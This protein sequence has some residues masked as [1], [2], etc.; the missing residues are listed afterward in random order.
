MRWGK[1]EPKPSKL[2]ILELHVWWPYLSILSAYRTHLPLG[3][4]AL[5]VCSSCVSWP[6]HLKH[7]GV[8]SVTKASLLQLH[9]M[10]S[11]DPHAFCLVSMFRGN[12]GG[13]LHNPLSSVSFMTV[14]SATWTRRALPTLASLGWTLPPRGH[15]CRACACY[16]V[17]GTENSLGLFFPQVLSLA[18]CRLALR[19]HSLISIHIRPLFNI[20]K[21]KPWLQFYNFWCSYSLQN[22]HLMFLFVLFS[23]FHCRPA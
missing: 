15:L 6:W 23:L 14:N 18:G 22:V 13:R 7:L 10:A 12:S 11:L 16:S 4:P 1:M 21:Y 9:T 2:Q 19:G 8:S 5:P 17:L 3:P 20:Y